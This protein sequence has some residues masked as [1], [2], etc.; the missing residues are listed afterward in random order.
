[1]KWVW[2]Q[3]TVEMKINNSSTI[4][5]SRTS[6][7]VILSVVPGS[8]VG[9]PVGNFP[10]R[11]YVAESDQIPDE[12]PPIDPTQAAQ[13]YLVREGR[14]G[15][16]PVTGDGMDGYDTN[17]DSDFFPTVGLDGQPLAPIQIPLDTQGPWYFWIELTDADGPILLNGDDPTDNDD[18]V[19]DWKTF[20]ANDGLHILIGYVDLELNA[21]GGIDQTIRQL[22]RADIP[23]PLEIKGC[24]ATGKEVTYELDGSLK[25]P[26]EDA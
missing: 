1:M 10:F 25:P 8:N 4:K 21:S 24:D 23:T 13:T 9:A 14:Y 15:I 22:L 19:N 3:L 12:E 6:K 18:A 11:I 7:G 2:E 17:P 16:T 5:V 20:P 26:K